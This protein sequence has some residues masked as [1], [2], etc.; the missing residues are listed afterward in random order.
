[1]ISFHHGSD[2]LPKFLEQQADNS[3]GLAS[4][5]AQTLRVV[6]EDGAGGA[7]FEAAPGLVI[8]FLGGELGDLSRVPAPPNGNQGKVFGTRSRLLAKP[9]AIGFLSF[10][11]PYC[12]R[13]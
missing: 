12:D 7:A 8:E 11:T 9:L 13:S 3:T 2:H 1:V 6:M 4:G 5:P 10:L